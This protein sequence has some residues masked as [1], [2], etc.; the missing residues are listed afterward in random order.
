MQVRFFVYCSMKVHKAVIEDGYYRDMIIDVSGGSSPLLGKVALERF[1][2]G[3]FAT[4]LN[5]ER[6]MVKLGYEKAQGNAFCMHL[7]DGGTLP[8]HLKYQ[9]YAIQMVDPLWRKNLVFAL[10]L[11][12]ARP[13][14]PLRCV[15]LLPLLWSLTPPPPPSAAAGAAPTA[16]TRPSPRCSRTCATSGSG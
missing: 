1:L 10:A 9:A 4:M 7:H 5:F 8:N 6:Y 2:D 3:E 14:P 15:S 12:C 13:S 11:R 16:P